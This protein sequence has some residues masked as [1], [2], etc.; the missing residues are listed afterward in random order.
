ME[1]TMSVGMYQFS[2]N[3]RQ[4]LSLAHQEAVKLGHSQ[5]EPGHIL[6][7][8]SQDTSTTGQILAEQGIDINA[9][10]GILIE[11]TPREAKEAA[12]TGKVDLHPA[13]QKTLERAIE[14]THQKNAAEIGPEHLLL[15]LILQ[16]DVRTQTVLQ[17]IGLNAGRV[18]QRLNQV[19]TPPKYHPEL[20]E[21]LDTVAT[22]RRLLE[23]S[24]D[25]VHRKRM[26]K[27]EVILRNFFK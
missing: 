5:I 24:D 7:G 18:R 3:A 13:T 17:A 23:T 11:Q 4:V 21:L 6:I 15:A 12:Q 16:E 10:R 2:H 27:I 8:L 14:V 1:S 26:D 22:C 20:E 25:P 9:L 19:T